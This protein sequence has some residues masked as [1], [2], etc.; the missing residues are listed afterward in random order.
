MFEC[1]FPPY[2]L[3]KETLPVIMMLYKNSKAMPF[4]A[5][6]ITDLFHIGK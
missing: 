5:D 1:L 3:P 2:G 6:G 4:S